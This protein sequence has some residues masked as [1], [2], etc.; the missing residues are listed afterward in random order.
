MTLQ[1]PP[2]RTSAANSEAGNTASAFYC[3]RC[4][5]PLTAIAGDGIFPSETVLSPAPILHDGWTVYRPNWWR[6]CTR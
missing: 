6:V 4:R 1:F 5:P 2:S 3:I